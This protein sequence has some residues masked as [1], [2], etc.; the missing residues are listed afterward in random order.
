MLVAVVL[1]L[2]ATM[3]LHIEDRMYLEKTNLFLGTTKA[4]GLLAGIST[5]AQDVALFDSFVH[6]L[7]ED[8]L[9]VYYQ[10][11]IVKS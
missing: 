11:E 2:D 6:L 10:D 8:Q 4:C 3:S 7:F 1:Q 5:E 9:A